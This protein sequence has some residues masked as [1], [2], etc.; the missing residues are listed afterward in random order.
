MQGNG[1]LDGA[2]DE[3][4]NWTGRI[5]YKPERL[6]MPY[7]WRKPQVVAVDWMGDLF[8]ENVPPEVWPATYK[9]M[10]ETPQHRYLVL[11]KRYHKMMT[12][13]A[14][15]FGD[16]L[17]NVYLG[18]TISNQKDADEAMVELIQCHS[19]GWPTWVSYEPALEAVRWNGFGWLSGLVCGGESGRNARPMPTEAAQGAR[20]Y[21]LAHGIPFTFK[22]GS[23]GAPAIIDGQRWFQ[24]P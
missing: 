4:G 16:P 24:F 9:V 22:Q 14:F 13:T 12:T 6:E 15:F 10:A 3:E 1:L 7:H 5:T 11:T 20:D 2:V 8:H 19:D 21:C 17:E 18:V 23:L